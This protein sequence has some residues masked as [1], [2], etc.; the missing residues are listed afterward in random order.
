MS[1]NV[2]N[3]PPARASREIAKSA[4]AYAEIFDNVLEIS[5]GDKPENIDELKA[6]ISNYFRLCQSESRLMGIEALALSCGV[7]RSTFWRWC[8]G[9]HCSE[10]WSRVCRQARQVVCTAIEA[11]TFE[12]VLSVPVGIFAL[13]QLGWS[14]NANLTIDTVENA[15]KPLSIADLPD[16]SSFIK[17]VEEEPTSKKNFSPRGMPSFDDL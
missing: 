5:K 10:E 8:N 12:G 2:S 11:L 1:N 4:G 13:K 6:K 16:I 9:Q 7:D 15:Q 3:Y 14:E 17:D